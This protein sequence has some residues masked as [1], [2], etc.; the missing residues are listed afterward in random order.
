MRV[1]YCRI[2][3]PTPTQMVFLHLF[4]CSSWADK[5]SLLFWFLLFSARYDEREMPW[6]VQKLHEEG[7]K[8]RQG[9]LLQE[10]PVWDGYGDNDSRD[11]YG[12]HAQP[13]GQPEGGT[14]ALAS[15]TSAAQLHVDWFSLKYTYN[16]PLKNRIY[17]HMIAI[18]SSESEG[19]IA[20]FWTAELK[21]EE[22]KSLFYFQQ[23]E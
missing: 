15:F 22:E 17:Y 21:K 4:T 5:T 19:C 23:L 7:E 16:T 11:G 10:M 8:G 9:W 2:D 6:E 1:W 12:H 18:V 20:Y 13:V 3:M 14:L